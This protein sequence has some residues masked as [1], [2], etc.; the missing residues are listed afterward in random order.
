M[1]PRNVAFGVL[2]L[3][4]S[5]SCGGSSQRSDGV[6][7]RSGGSGGGSAG[8]TG[9]VGPGTGGATAA[10]G[11]SGGSGAGGDASGGTGQAGGSGGDAG[12]GASGASGAAAGSGG[13]PPV[14]ACEFSV[15]ASLSEK[16]QTVGIVEWSST[17][18]NVSTARI[19]FGLRTC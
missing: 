8:G 9:G 11:G 19:E 14:A 7:G 12:S 18:S 4:G 1:S 3:L 6:A 2:L 15:A 10:T 16:I 13:T 17:L 5:S